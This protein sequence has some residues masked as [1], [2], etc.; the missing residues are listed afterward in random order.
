MVIGTKIFFWFAAAINGVNF[1]IWQQSYTAGLS[2]WG[3]IMIAYFLVDEIID[4]INRGKIL[5]P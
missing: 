1:G 3:I 5:S 2:C 4:A